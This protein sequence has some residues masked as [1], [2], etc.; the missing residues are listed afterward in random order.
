M[1]G[2][3]SY[4]AYASLWNES[5]PSHWSVL[6]MYALAKEKSICGCVDLPLLSV[7]LDAQQQICKL[8]SAFPN[9]GRPVSNQLK[10]CRFD[11]TKYIL[12]RIKKDI[13]SRSASRRAGSDCALSGLEGF[14]HQ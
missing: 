5:L 9:Y 2:Y 6:P 10:K 13:C 8:P 4:T 1:S 7:Y 14:E 11:S 12:A 3:Q